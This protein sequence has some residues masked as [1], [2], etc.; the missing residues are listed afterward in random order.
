MNIIIKIEKIFLIILILLNENNLDKTV[1]EVSNSLIELSYEN[2][3]N[4]LNINEFYQKIKNYCE[5]CY[6]ILFY[7]IIACSQF[8]EEQYYEY[9]NIVGNSHKMNLKPVHHNRLSKT[10]KDLNSN[11]FHLQK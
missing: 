11:L 10:I 1:S 9:L 6:Q 4:R 7:F 2:N 8:T 3:I 5:I